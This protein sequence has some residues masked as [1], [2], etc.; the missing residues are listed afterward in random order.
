MMTTACDRAR[1]DDPAGFVVGASVAGDLADLAQQ[2]FARFVHAAPGVADCLGHPR[3]EA[4][5]E[6]GDLARYDP[7]TATVI[8]RV[9]ATAPSLSGS[10]VHELAHH[11]EVACPTHHDLRPEFLVAQRHP[12]GTPWFGQTAWEQRPSEQ[13]AEAV[14]EVVLGERTRNQLALHLE[15]ATTRLVAGWLTGES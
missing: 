10:L 3:L 2:T 12:A 1:A 15:P 11:L 8:V 13:F 14:V 6:L 7:A 5:P 4:A 9:P